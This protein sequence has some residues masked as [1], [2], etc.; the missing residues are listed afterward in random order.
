MRPS[1]GFLNPSDRILRHLVSF[2]KTASWSTDDRAL[3]HRCF[4]SFPENMRCIGSTDG[5]IAIDCQDANNKHRHTYLLHNEFS[6]TT[7]SL[8]ELDAAISHVS[9]LFEIRKVLLRSTPDDIIA[10]MTNHY[11]CHIILTRRGKGVW[12]PKQLADPLI[13][14]I[15]IAFLGD[16]LYGITR[17]SRLP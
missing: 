16:R 8:P 12:F 10:L 3:I 4:S 11:S 15:D 13:D 2:P 9:E 6:G 7:L 5:W 17:G 14:I 1:G